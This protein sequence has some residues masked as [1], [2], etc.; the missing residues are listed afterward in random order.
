M[1]PIGREPD[2]QAVRALRI[3]FS[4]TLGL[5]D[6]LKC[7]RPSVPEHRELLREFLGA[8][9]SLNPVSRRHAQSLIPQRDYINRGRCPR[10]RDRAGEGPERI[11]FLSAILPWIERS[12]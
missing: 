11:R 12:V 3:A 10:V 7:E 6:A 8:A 1:E 5:D 4:P 9:I 2:P